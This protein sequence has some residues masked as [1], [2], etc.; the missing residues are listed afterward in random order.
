MQLGSVLKRG[1]A[2]LRRISLAGL[3]SLVLV[4]GLYVPAF[5]QDVSSTIVAGDFITLKAALENPDRDTEVVVP[6]GTYVFS[7]TVT[8]N[9]DLVLKNATGQT[10]TF[11]L[12]MFNN[13]SG[14]L[15]KTMMDVTAGSVT[16]AGENNE[17]LVFDGKN[18]FPAFD[19]S[20][21][22]VLN[23]TTPIV[24][25]VSTKGVFLTLQTDTQA[26]IDHATLKMPL[27]VEL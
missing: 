22:Q 20:K 17:S 5:A 9:K 6:G 25:N 2:T 12:G 3:A 21:D 18:D 23:H 7:D 19:H 14:S 10:V 1:A 16:F 11:E 26:T 13:D 27:T 15:G 4:G 24:T 8:V